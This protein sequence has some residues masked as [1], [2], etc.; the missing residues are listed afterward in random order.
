MNPN[1]SIQRYP[2]PRG[3]TTVE[4]VIIIIVTLFVGFHLGRY[5]ENRHKRELV[6]MY[7]ESQVLTQR[8]ALARAVVQTNDLR[9]NRHKE[10]CKKPFKFRASETGVS[11][12]F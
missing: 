9:E 2:A 6:K 4:V 5:Y 12:E 10:F 8:I 11:I 3:W 7:R 1:K